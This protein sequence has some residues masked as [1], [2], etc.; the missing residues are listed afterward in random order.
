MLKTCRKKRKNVQ[1]LKLRIGVRINKASGT[2]FQIGIINSHLDRKASVNTFA[3][4]RLENPLNA[5]ALKHPDTFNP[6]VY[7]FC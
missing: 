7:A 2:S 6:F 4:F 5:R 3:P 1:K